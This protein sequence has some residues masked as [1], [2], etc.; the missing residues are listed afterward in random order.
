MPPSPFNMDSALQ[1][2]LVSG[3]VGT[4]G[5]SRGVKCADLA[6]PA[7]CQAG[8]LCLP[9]TCPRQVLALQAH[10]PEPRP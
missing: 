2:A 4:Y 5:T 7:S 9:R 3:D 10:T 8:D 6:G 1:L